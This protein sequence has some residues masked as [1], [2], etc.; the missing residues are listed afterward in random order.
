MI[1]PA[2]LSDLNAI[3][4]IALIEASKYDKLLA[5]R[6]KI[7]AGIT[8]AISSAKHFCWV[9]EDDGRVNGAIVA[10]SSKNMWAQRDN[11]IVALWKSVVVGDGRKMMREF[12]KWVDARRIIRVAGIVP[13]NNHVD[14]LVWSLMERLGFRKYGGAYL[15][16]N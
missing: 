6:D 7:R 5:D 10:L 12:L 13:D 16:Y 1:R 15:L 11:C 4:E 3:N 14:P 9:S 2:T 8:S